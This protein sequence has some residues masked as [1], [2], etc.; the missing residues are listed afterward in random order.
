MESN[1]FKLVDFHAHTGER[2]IQNAQDLRNLLIELRDNTSEPE[3]INLI[4]PNGDI[5]T[6]A[7]GAEFGFVQFER[8]LADSPYLIAIERQKVPTDNYR[9][10]DAGGTPTPIPEH[11]CIPT[12]KVI[13]IVMY[14]FNHL[15]IPNYIEWEEF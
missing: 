9:N 5:L 15:T 13:D 8:A 14:Y 10:V 7:I 6:I 2:P 12:E 4:S 11:A 3:S 1:E